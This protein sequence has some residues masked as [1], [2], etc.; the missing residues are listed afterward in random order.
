MFDFYVDEYVSFLH[1]QR[2]LQLEDAHSWSDSRWEA[3]FG[4][5]CLVRLQIFGIE[6]DEMWRYLAQQCISNFAMSVA[7]DLPE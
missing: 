6:N 7:S 2:L 3:F 5:H 1:F 4:Q